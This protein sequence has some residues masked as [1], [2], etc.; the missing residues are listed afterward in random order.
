MSNEP[1]TTF[2]NGLGGMLPPGTY[3]YPAGFGGSTRE[4][5]V[6]VNIPYPHTGAGTPQPDNPGDLLNK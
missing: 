2:S 5:P 1:D 6:C 4:K 3:C